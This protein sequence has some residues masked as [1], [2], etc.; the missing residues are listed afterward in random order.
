MPMGCIRANWER[1]WVSKG[2]RVV[3]QLYHEGVSIAM[4]YCNISVPKLW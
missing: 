3:V 2:F 4:L 1:N